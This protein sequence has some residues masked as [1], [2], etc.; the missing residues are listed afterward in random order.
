MLRSA[1]CATTIHGMQGSSNGRIERWVGAV[2]P[3]LSAS[4]LLAGCPS[5]ACDP[6]ATQECFCAGGRDG[7]Q[8]CSDDGARWLDCQC[9]SDCA[10]DDDAVDDDDV[11]NDDDAVDDDDS[12]DPTSVPMIEIPAGAFWMGCDAGDDCADSES[13]ARQVTLSAFA[14]D[15]TEVTVAAYAA[16][17]DAG[18][19]TEPYTHPYG[20]TWGIDGQQDHPITCVS[21][22]QAEAYCSWVGK[23]LL[24]EAEWEKAARG[25]DQ[26]TFPW[27]DEE[28]DCSRA[29]FNAGDGFGC[30]L[31]ST[32]PVGSTP[33]GASPFG[34]LDLAGNCEAWV[35]DWYGETYYQTGPSIDPLGP[36]SG[37]TK[38][39]RG[40]HWD[41][42]PGHLRATIRGQTEADYQG[43]DIGI[44][45][46]A[47][48]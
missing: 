16:C 1:R 13:P 12:A 10:D 20:C 14:I 17:F 18:A 26:R 6:G 11:V 44:R 32:W 41:S 19:C 47:D 29:I 3:V 34:V 42:L 27:G 45:C 7:A 24:T 5:A 39:Y 22:H 2:L 37:Y 33:G 35:Q 30:G 23:R 36:E 38:V 40:G 28:P 8:V 48:L 15:R 46:A 43:H 25:E 4:L 21:W 9:D 31:E